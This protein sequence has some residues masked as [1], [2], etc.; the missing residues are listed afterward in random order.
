MTPSPS[1]IAGGQFA[2]RV[3]VATPVLDLH[4]PTRRHFAERPKQRV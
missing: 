2:R 4:Q 1:A 3:R